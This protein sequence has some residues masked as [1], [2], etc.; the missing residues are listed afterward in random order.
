MLE[1]KPDANVIYDMRISI[2]YVPV[3]EGS[4]IVT[5][6]YASCGCYKKEINTS[7]EGNEVFK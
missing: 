1:G 6:I 3:S 7:D 5:T 2:T 4:A